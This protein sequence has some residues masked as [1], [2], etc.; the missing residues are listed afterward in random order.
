MQ[1]SGSSDTEKSPNF[2]YVGHTFLRKIRTVLAISALTSEKS[3]VRTWIFPIFP[4]IG[5]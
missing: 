3:G 4:M 2:P 5:P 1:S